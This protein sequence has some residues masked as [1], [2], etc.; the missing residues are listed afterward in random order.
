MGLLMIRIQVI[1]LGDGKHG[2]NK[3]TPE[4]KALVD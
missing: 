1:K 4:Y 3:K 2:T